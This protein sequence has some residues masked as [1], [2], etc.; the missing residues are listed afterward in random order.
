MG[1]LL[2]LMFRYDFNVMESWE[3]FVV[4]KHTLPGEVA[5]VSNELLQRIEGALYESEQGTICSTDRKN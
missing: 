1:H 3:E 2:Y 5:S 4:S